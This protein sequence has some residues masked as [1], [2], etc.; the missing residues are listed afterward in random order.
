[1]AFCALSEAKG[2]VIKMKHFNK[3][4]YLK[5]AE[6]TIE[7]FK[8]I[9]E[10]VADISNRNIE[11]IFLIASGGSLAIMNPIY[12]V[13]KQKTKLPIYLEVAAEIVATGH[14]QL[15]ENSLVITASKSGM[16]KETVAMAA[17]CKEKNI[18]IVALVGKEGTLLHKLATY[19][20]LGKAKDAPEFE[21]MQLF[22]LLFGLLEKRGEFDGY[23]EFKNQL[24][25]IPGDLARFRD[26]F[27]PKA[28]EIAKAFHNVPYQL[29]I[30]SGSIWGEIYSLTM[31]VWEE[32]Q[33]LK[34][35]AVTSAE[36]FH[37][38]LEI[39]EK[40][41]PVVLVKT[42]DKTRSLD[43]RVEK[44]L[45]QICDNF[46]VID[47]R[48]YQ[49]STVKTEYREYLMAPIC[50]AL[51]GDCLSSY[52]EFYSGHSLNIRRYYGVMDY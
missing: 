27:S 15:S 17:W 22:V 7:T 43:E 42:D 46:F 44:F 11:N 4:K 41:T 29:W 51:L 23:L 48:D 32:M 24:K 9:E 39:V 6:L 50:S 3:T 18:P 34:T 47:L 10:V 1:M 30:G 8:D 13:A 40:D 35:K 28:D 19:T 25:T 36:F 26:E 33:W 52:Y 37:G 21:Y 31:C 38:T 12:F 16:T 45:P 49:F 14:A 2:M 20:V 5:E